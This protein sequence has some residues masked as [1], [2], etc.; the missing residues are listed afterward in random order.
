VCRANR[1]PLRATRVLAALGALAILVLAVGDVLAGRTGPLRDNATTLA[2]ALAAELTDTGRSVLVLATA[3]EPTREAGARMPAFG[4]DDIT[5]VPGAAAR[6]AGWDHALTSG[7]PGG[8]KTAIAQAATAGVLFVVLPDRAALDEFTHAAGNLAATVSA[9]SDGRPV[10]RL[11]P[12]GGAAVLISPE[13]AKQAVT[14][15]QPPTTLGAAGISPVDARPPD[16]AVR[17]SEGGIGRLL[18]LAAEYENAWQAT[19][20]NQPAPIVRAWGHLVAVSVPTEAADV[21]VYVPNTIRDVLLLVQ[22]AVLLFTTLT[23][24]PGRR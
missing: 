9:T 1:L 20:D 3:G 19:I 11:Q 21:R 4:D 6:L 14:G 5:A 7:D 15:G 10:V 23:A 8:T 17:V 12:A 24:I 2:P 13:Q 16:V 22:A 18:V